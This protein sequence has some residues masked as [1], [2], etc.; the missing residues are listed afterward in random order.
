MQEGDIVQMAV[1]IRSYKAKPF[2]YI[3]S[4]VPESIGNRYTREDL[5]KRPLFQLIELSGIKLT[6]AQ[7]SVNAVSKEGTV[8]RQSRSAPILMKL[9]EKYL[10]DQDEVSFARQKAAV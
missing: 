1:R 2:A 8:A 4:Y 7:H 9:Y 3:V 5:T 10:N 6:S